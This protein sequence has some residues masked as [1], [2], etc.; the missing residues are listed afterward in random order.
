MKKIVAISL[1]VLMVLAFAVSAFAVEGSSPEQP[2]TDQKITILVT[3]GGSATYKRNND[4]SVTYTA[5]PAEGHEFTKWD[6]K[7]EYE[8]ISGDIN[9]PVITIKPIGDIQALACFDGE[10]EPVVNP[11]EEKESPK[12]GNMVAPALIVAVVALVGTA[13]AAKKAYCA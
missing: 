6:I 3:K 7:G 1:V 13:Y 2:G 8:I 10:T 9:S 12:T 4:G 11:W 5:E